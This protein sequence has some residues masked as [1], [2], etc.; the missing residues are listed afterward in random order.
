MSKPL[1]RDFSSAELQRLIPRAP[2]VVQGIAL[3]TRSEWAPSEWGSQIIY[4]TVDF[5]VEE[6]LVGE[7]K[8]ADQI[9]FRF[10]GGKIGD[11]ELQVSHSTSLVPGERAIILLRQDHAKLA[12]MAS[13]QAKVPIGVPIR[14][15]GKDIAVDA[16][17]VQLKTF[18]VRKGAG[19]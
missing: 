16:L 13:E 4:T 5:K 3:A 11:T 6:V 14:V 2:L 15:D 7:L 8:G 19:R 9:S 18:T 10:E 1:D 12:L 17:K